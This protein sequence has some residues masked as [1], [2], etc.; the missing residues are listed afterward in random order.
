M[1]RGVRTACFF[2]GWVVLTA[3]IG[4]FAPLLM[5]SQRASWWASRQWATATLWW[6]RIC[7]GVRS[8]V[9]GAPASRL[10][11]S[12]HQSAW[13]T[14]MLWKQLGNP[15]FILKRELYWIPV[16]GWYLWRTG[17]IAID[18]RNA[19]G[20]MRHVLEQAQARHAQGRS[21]VI[22]PEGTRV[23][24]S[25]D[26][27]FHGGI[28][29]LSET[30]G[31]PVTPAALNAGYFWPKH[32]LQKSPGMAVL[33]FLPAMPAAA[34]ST[35]PWLAEL[36]RAINAASDAIAPRANTASGNRTLP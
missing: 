20:A 10:I 24:P 15:C 19:R 22:F 21:I 34:G 28:A 16:F 2:A 18:R 4:L 35:G 7:C 9:Q 36:K 23:Q 26:A 33:E 14:I 30:L 32:R 6:L 27:A 17:Q 13:D 8:V 11:A 12:K 25:E 31:E 1:L 5:P 29:R 3:F